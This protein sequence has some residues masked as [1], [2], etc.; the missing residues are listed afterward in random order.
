MKTKALKDY[1]L[2]EPPVSAKALYDILNNCSRSFKIFCILYTAMNIGMFDSLSTPRT[3]DEL[4]EKLGIDPNITSNVCK[5]LADLGLIEEKNG[6]YKNTEIS[7]LYLRTTSPL[8]Q[9]HVFKNLKN[10]FK[11]WEKLEDILKNGPIIMGEEKFFQDHIHSHASEALCGELQRTV[12][13]IAEIPEFKRARKLLDLGGGHGLYAIAFTMLNQDLKAYVYDFPDVIED[14]K[15]YI[16]KFNAD[17][18]KFIPG[19]FFTDDIGD[20]YDIVFFSYN[21]GGKNPSLVPKIHTSLNDKGLFINKHAFYH[22]EELS[23]NPLLDAEWNLVAFSGVK[24][25]KKI[26]S[27]EGDLTF[28]E[29][30]KLLEKYF[31]IIKIIDTPD[32]AN[33]HLSKLGDALDSKIII[34]KKIAS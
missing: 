15:I 4:C 26:Y 28:E 31:S 18:V 14:A 7:N 19:N 33:P 3:V 1:L 23:K 13:I 24:K 20:G 16:K 17:R 25:G 6:F 30:I 22:K 21:P 12:N 5:V 29:Y 8:C 11:L 34:A 2:N 27:F 10:G 9:Y 32:F